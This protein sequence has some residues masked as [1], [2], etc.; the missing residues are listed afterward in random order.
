MQT[1]LRQSASAAEE[2]LRRRRART[3]LLQF[4][5]EMFPWFI[6]GEHHRIICDEIEALLSGSHDKLMIFAPPRHGKSILVSV[7]LPAWYLGRFP[8]KQVIAISYNKELSSDFGRQVRNM[9]SSDRYPRVF[10]TIHLRRDSSASNRWHTSADGVYISSGV[11]GTLSGRGADLAIIDDPIK[12][13]QEAES[14]AHKEKLWAAYDSDIQTRLMPGG[15]IVVMHTRW[16]DDDFAGRLQEREPGQWKVIKLPAILDE[17]TENEKALWP[18]FFSLDMLRDRR[19]NTSKRTWASL[20]Q[21]SPQPDG[22]IYFNPEWFKDRYDSSP[23]AL[24][25]YISADFAVKEPQG[26]SDDPDYTEIAVWGVDTKG[27][28]YAVDWWFGKETSDK[29]IEHIIR[30][31]RQYRALKFFGEGGVIRHAIEPQLKKRMREEKAIFPV[32]WLNPIG[33]KQA[34]ARAFQGFASMGKVKF[35][36]QSSWGVHVMGHLLSFPAGEHDDA[37]D[38]CSIMGRAI[39]QMHSASV[40]RINTRPDRVDRS[41]K[42]WRVV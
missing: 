33:D 32:E 26:Q 5:Q 41:V 24:K 3:S 31:A 34:S 12:G 10:P 21:Q 25:H 37:V 29:W 22:G 18:E 11:G 23:F 38:A 6:V 4:A 36:R 16:G 39:E 35:P 15:K 13:R 9:V 17:N 40:E 27:D 42:R 28:I 8:N 20:Y 7:L 14:K 30:L 2:L 1:E 19:K